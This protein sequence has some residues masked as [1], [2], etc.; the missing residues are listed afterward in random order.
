MSK[1][2]KKIVRQ[3]PKIIPVKD[4]EG[5][6]DRFSDIHPFL[7]QISGYGGGALLLLLSPVKTGKSTIINNLLLNKDFYDAQELFDMTHIIS[8][9]IANDITSRFLQKAFDTH[10]HYDDG[11]I[12]SIVNRQKS[13]EKE[14]QPQI[15]MVLDDCLGS[16]KREA[17]VNHL[18]S[19]YRHYGIRLLIMSSQKFVGAVSPVV[20]ANAT[21]VIIGSPYPNQKELAS[22]CEVYGDMYGSPEQM[23]AL[24]KAA[25]PDRYDF[26]HLDLQSN[27]PLMY[28]NFDQ[29]IAEGDRNLIPINK[30]FSLEKNNIELQ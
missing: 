21:N 2:E 13:F 16:I 20:R 3:G 27:P 12:D 6:D 9:T 24:Y 17:R 10:D 25:T 1:K 4:P 5:E 19:R 11:I 29:L 14:E 30:K 15:A 26:I 7:P 22:I 28:R 18:A 23:M 8:N